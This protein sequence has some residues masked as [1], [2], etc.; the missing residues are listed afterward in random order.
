MSAKF[1]EEQISVS[2]MSGMTEINH[3][4]VQV[5]QRSVRTMWRR[6]RSLSA[7][8]RGGTEISQPYVQEEQR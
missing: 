8:C 5:E 3:R 2:H 6:N 1:R 7:I 4:C